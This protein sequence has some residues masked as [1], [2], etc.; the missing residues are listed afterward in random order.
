M[1]SY[2]ITRLR[3]LVSSDTVRDRALKGAAVSVAAVGGGHALRFASNLILTRLLF[4][5]AFGLM[6][7]VQ[8]VLSGLA[9]LSTFGLRVSVMQNPRGDEEDFLNT[10]WTMQVLR[11][12]FLWVMVCLLAA[13]MAQFYN[14]PLLAG[15]LPVAGTTLLIQGFYTTNVLTAQRHMRIT[16]YSWITLVAQVIQI[17]A[18][19]IL[20]YVLQSVWALAIGSVFHS[21]VTLVLYKR[22]V[23]G[24]RNRFRFDRGS[25]LEIFKLG[26]FLFFSTIATYA[27]TQGDR[28]ILGLAIPIDL[29]GVY[30]IAFTLATLPSTL[31]NSVSNSVVFPLYRMRHPSESL[32]N[33]ANLFRARRLVAGGTLALTVIMA[34]IAPGFVSVLYDDR[35]IL[36]GPITVILC[37]AN[38]P[39]IV[40]NGVMNAALAKGDSL[41]FMVMNVTN[42]VLQ[43][44]LMYMLVML[45]GILGAAIA[46][47]LAQLI[48]YP[49][50]VVF[51]RKYENWDVRGDLLLLTMGLASTGLVC[52]LHWEEILQLI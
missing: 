15:I 5:E 52:V 44:A 36:A 22:F 8:V 34:I 32:T 28:A 38:V 41:R 1:A 27:I 12:I 2:V 6:A 13:P 30:G 50:L 24:I 51:M 4:P 26:K 19:S 7:L 45:I 35:Y 3:Q 46:I 17:L 18:M 48:S 40:F 20:A 23:P 31:S 33:R 9:L 42:A 21:V 49:L 39:L 11:G 25:M 37:T 29:L 10:A 16:R 14:Q 47:G 43:T